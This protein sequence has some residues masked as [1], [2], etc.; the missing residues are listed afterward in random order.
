MPVMSN[1]NV[2]F[3]QLIYNPLK[4]GVIV[5]PCAVWEMGGIKFVCVPQSKTMHRFSLNF[6]DMFT[7]R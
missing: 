2:E 7:P 6:Q 5:V 4:A 1:D 3:S